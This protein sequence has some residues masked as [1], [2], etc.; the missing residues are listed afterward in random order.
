MAHSNLQAIYVRRVN[1]EEPLRLGPFLGGNP[2]AASADTPPTETWAP[3]RL[4]R[5][6]DT[7]HKNH[8]LSAF[9]KD[10]E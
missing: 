9:G 1:F 3:P 10:H 2:P 8:I 5:D 4:P 6:A 7:M